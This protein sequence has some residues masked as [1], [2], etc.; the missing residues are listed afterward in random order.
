MVIQNIYNFQEEVGNALTRT[1]K[2]IFFL[3]LPNQKVSMHSFNVTILLDKN[4]KSLNF[5]KEGALIDHM[6]KL[7]PLAMQLEFFFV[8]SFFFFFGK[9]IIVGI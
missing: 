6:R 2:T 8:I 9:L 5:T 4:L 1:R 7:E 3:L